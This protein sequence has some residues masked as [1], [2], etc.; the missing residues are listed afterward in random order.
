[1]IN[2]LKT[3]DEWKIQLSI[4]INF[5]YSKDT[6]EKR[7]MHSMTDNTEIMIANETDHIIK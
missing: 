2:Y 6:D 7:T 3:L 5:M 1:M 4:A